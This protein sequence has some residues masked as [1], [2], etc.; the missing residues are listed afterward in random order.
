MHALLHWVPDPEAGHHW[1]TSLMETPGHLW[2]VWVSYFWGHCSFLLSPG[3]Y[4][5]LFVPSKSLF[6]HSYVSSSSSMVGLTVTSSKTP[7]VAQMVK[8][9]STVQETWVRSLGW[10]DPLEKEMAIHSSTLAWKIP[11]TEEPGRLQSRGLQRVGH[12]W[13]TFISFPFLQDGLCHTQVCCMY[14]SN[15]H[16]LYARQCY[17]HFEVLVAQSCPT[18]CNPMDCIACEDPLFMGFPRQ[19]SG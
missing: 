14:H 10:E 15:I 5:V 9:L 17:K 3:V 12:D 8:R 7:L 1:P 19:W 6:P 11:W 4:K 18:L 16:L 13:A 2:Q